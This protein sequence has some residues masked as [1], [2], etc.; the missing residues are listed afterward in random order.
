MNSIKIALTNIVKYPVDAFLFDSNKKY[1]HMQE[2]VKIKLLELMIKKDIQKVEL[3]C[4]G[5]E[6]LVF[7]LIVACDEL[8]LLL[9]IHFFNH[10]TK[11]FI[12]VKVLELSRLLE[13]ENKEIEK[14]NIQTTRTYTLTQDSEH[15]VNAK[16]Y[17]FQDYELETDDKKEIINALKEEFYWTQLQDKVQLYVSDINPHM[18]LTAVFLRDRGLFVELLHKDKWEDKYTVQDFSNYELIDT[19]LEKYET[20][21]LAAKY[22]LDEETLRDE[23]LLRAINKLGR[24]RRSRK[25]QPD[26]DFSERQVE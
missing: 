16:R 13:S 20:K 6:P 12:K 3:Y 22:L 1:E 14:A 19:L 23:A 25:D 5:V 24:S 2:E 18:V 17:V 21:K 26:L 11:Q 15:N 9:D 7:D 8:K 10:H 4:A